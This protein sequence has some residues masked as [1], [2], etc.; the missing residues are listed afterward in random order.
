MA[1]VALITDSSS[2]LPQ[3]ILQKYNI[4]VVPLI[5]IWGEQMYEDGVDI[6]PEEFYQKLANTKIM[7]TTSQ[8][9]VQN[10]KNAFE[11]LLAEDHEVFGMFLSSKL[12][13]TDLSAFQGRDELTSGQ[14]KIHIF[15]AQ[16]TS[17]AMGFQVLAVARAAAEGASISECKALAEHARNNT[18]VFF[19]V[20]TLEFLHR[21]GRIG[22]AQ[23]LLGT[24][25]NLKPILTV[26]DGKVESVER[27]RT[28]SKAIERIVEIVAEKCKGSSSVRLASLHANAAEDAS[29]L[30]KSTSQAVNPQEAISTEL[31]PVLGTHTGPGTI[32]LAYMTGL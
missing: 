2:S 23:R 7:P 15:D 24:A 8:V 27:V 3:E 30:L 12:S 6:Q 17:M 31:S 9:S 19:M 13:G 22:G 20:D 28:K 11:R 18:G 29:A 26:D 10:M 1:K 14:D 5:S 25:L 4:T 32:G 21:G 16:T